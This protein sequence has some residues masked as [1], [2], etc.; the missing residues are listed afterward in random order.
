[1]LFRDAFGRTK[2]AVAGVVDEDIDTAETIGGGFN[3]SGKSWRTIG[4]IE[5]L[6][7]EGIGIFFNELPQVGF[8]AGSAEY[9]VPGGKELLGQFTP[10]PTANSSYEPD[11][12]HFRG[13]H[14]CKD[15]SNSAQLYEGELHNT[16]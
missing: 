5:R 13:P 14:I 9:R 6:H 11:F 10:Q 16:G 4:K 1:M 7:R 3:E 15:F 8:A 12:M 2:E